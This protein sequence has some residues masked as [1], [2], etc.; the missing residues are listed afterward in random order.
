MRKSLVALAALAAGAAALAFSGPAAAE[1]ALHEDG[2]GFVAAEDVREALGW[3]DARL[4]AASGELEFVAETGTV[5]T[6]TWDCARGGTEEVLPQRMDLVVTQS[7]AV[8]AV[9]RSSWRGKVLGFRL[10]GYDGRGASSAAPEGPAPG[11]C[12][13][14]P[15]QLVEG[16]QRTDEQPG[17]TVLT[18]HHDGVAHDLPAPR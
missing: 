16:S 14:G 9:A 13:A 5:T 8:T 1:P 17:R 2:T 11:S 3:D 12:P 15:W 4:R 7:R 10:T 6:T 18:V